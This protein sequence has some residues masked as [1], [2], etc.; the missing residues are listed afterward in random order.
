MEIPFHSYFTLTEIAQKILLS[1]HI[2]LATNVSFTVSSITQLKGGPNTTP[3]SQTTLHNLNIY[4]HQ[5]LHLRKICKV[6]VQ[7]LKDKITRN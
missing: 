5:L 4:F 6:L 2:S 1:T 7:H 3:I